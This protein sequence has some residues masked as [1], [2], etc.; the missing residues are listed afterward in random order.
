MLLRK[1][2]HYIIRNLA[3]IGNTYICSVCGK[4]SGRFLDYGVKTEV[5][6]AD[7]IIGGGYRSN[8][9]CPYCDSNDRIRWIDYCIEKFT[10]LYETSGGAEAVLHIAPERQIEKKL[11]CNTRLSY[12]SGDIKAG[13]ADMIVDITSMSQFENQRFD[14]IILNHVLEHISN[15]EQAIFE[16]LRC[17]KK[18]GI[19]FFS[20]PICLGKETLELDGELTKEER[21][22]FYGQEDHVRLYGEKDVIERMWKLGI[23]AKMYVITDYLTE[24]EIESGNFMKGDRIFIGKKV[25]EAI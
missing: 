19:I 14:V 2:R 9:T 4:S 20:F 16:I 3:K 7:T 15:E 25:N 10:D 1:M 11:K 18:D 12:I 23:N 24:K 13:I 5:F 21:L 6:H 22:K 17:L 8:V